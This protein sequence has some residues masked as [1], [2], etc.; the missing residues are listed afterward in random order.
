M[1]RM[2]MAATPIQSEFCVTVNALCV[3]SLLFVVVV[4]VVAFLF[5]Q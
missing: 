5:A 3:E 2:A 1:Y 4:V